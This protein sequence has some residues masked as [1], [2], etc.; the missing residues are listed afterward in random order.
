MV[1]YMKDLGNHHALLCPTV[2]FLSYPML[3]DNA[4]DLGLRRCQEMENMK[5][6]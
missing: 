6:R 4:V 2:G 3:A 5:N 1:T